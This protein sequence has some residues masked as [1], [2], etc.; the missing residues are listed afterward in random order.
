MGKFVGAPDG[1]TGSEMARNSGTMPG[2]RPGSGW[3]NASLGQSF[4]QTNAKH[5]RLIGHPKS[6]C[7]T[8]IKRVGA[9]IGLK[10]GDFLLLDTLAAFSQPQDWEVGQSAIVWPSNSYLMERTGFSLSALKR[11]LRRLG[12][13][14]VIAFRD[15]PNGKRWGHR[16]RNGLIVEAYGFDLSPLSARVEEFEHLNKRLVDERAACERL[17]RQITTTRRYIRAQLDL[18]IQEGLNE[19]RNRWTAMF[20][21]LISELPRRAVPSGELNLVLQDF[22]ALKTAID[23]EL[24]AN[25]QIE[26]TAEL[27][28]KEANNGPHIQ[29]TIQLESVTC[30]AQNACHETELLDLKTADPLPDTT[31]VD[32]EQ[33]LQTTPETIR[34]SCPEFT[35]WAD[36][37]IRNWASLFQAANQL[38]P[39]AGIT[40]RTWG[41]VIQCLGIQRAS[42]ALALVFDKHCDGEIKTPDRYLLG[43]L[44]KAAT[45]DLHLDRSFFGRIDRIKGALI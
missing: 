10:A 38:R 39:L 1:A 29:H 18:T 30:N 3:R 14:G 40:D 37:P 20:N 13:R 6:R 23:A 16:D 44:K 7:I 25:N 42:A 24:T 5:G 17:K 12:E 2:T 36:I 11:H 45:G 22:T 35:Q 31:A 27:D 34:R 9:A 28:P 43:M 32:I 33:P 26:D 4:A 15:S 41:K 8:A 19:I 21:D